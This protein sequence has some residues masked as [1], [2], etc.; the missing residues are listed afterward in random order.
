[1]LTAERRTGR[2]RCGWLGA[3]REAN[4]SDAPGIR[5]G[6]ARAA[7]VVVAAMAVGLFS[8]NSAHGGGTK[9]FDIVIENGQVV[10]KK[11][12]RVTKGDAVVLRWSSDKQ[13]QLH[14]HGYDVETTVYPGATAEMTIQARATGRFPVEIHAERGAGGGHAHGH[15]TIFHLEVYPD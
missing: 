11:S 4:R 12:V 13:L 2:H 3:R 8:P 6:F 1:L 15:R 5:A 9:T 10:G 14:L 7:L